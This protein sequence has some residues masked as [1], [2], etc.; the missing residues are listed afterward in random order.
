M[1]QTLL[2]SGVCFMASPVIE[3]NVVCRTCG[4]IVFS[5]AASF[6][7]SI[8]LSAAGMNVFGCILCVFALF[9]MDSSYSAVV[10]GYWVYGEIDTPLYPPMKMYYGVSS[11]VL[12]VDCIDDAKCA[13]MFQKFSFS[14]EGDGV[15]ALEHNDDSCSF[16]FDSAA[17]AAICEDWK[18]N[19]YSE[20]TLIMGVVTYWS[21][22][23]TSFQR[24][25]EFGDVSCQKFMGM[26]G[27]IIGILAS[28][29]A[30]TGYADA[31]YSR[32]TSESHPSPLRE[33]C[34]LFGF[35]RLDYSPS[36]GSTPTR[37][38]YEVED[39]PGID[40]VVKHHTSFLSK[41][42]LPLKAEEDGHF[43]VN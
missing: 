41:F 6:C 19:Q 5:V 34:P 35:T 20:S 27:T 42:D 28:V 17:L 22:I 8:M 14:D 33:T 4:G 43:V 39:S 40:S 25:T 15:Y 30:L 32:W 11:R 16:P 31:C 38:E 24:S 12:A 10:F 7:K 2:V 18:D 1:F 9:G 37:S 13:S 26:V 36:L 23:L 29:M 21:S 3:F